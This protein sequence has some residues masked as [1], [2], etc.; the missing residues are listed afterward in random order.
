MAYVS[1][2]N[3]KK[4]VKIQAVEPIN[5]ICNGF[6]IQLY[7]VNITAYTKKKQKNRSPA[8]SSNHVNLTVD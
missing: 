6:Y 1:I 5:T 2:R 3:Y 4:V 7:F 8:I